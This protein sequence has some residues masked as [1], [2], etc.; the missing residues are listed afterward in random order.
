MKVQEIIG[1]EMHDV[2]QKESV[3]RKLK[4]TPSLYKW[5]INM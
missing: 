3:K 4:K 1:I 2:K 5:A